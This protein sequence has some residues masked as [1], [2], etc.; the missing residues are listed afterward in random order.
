MY[1]SAAGRRSRAHLA[2]ACSGRMPMAHFTHSNITK[3]PQYFTYCEVFSAPEK[4]RTPDTTVRSR[5]LYPAEL[6]THTELFCFHHSLNRIDFT[7]L[8]RFCQLAIL[9]FPDFFV[10]FWQGS[11]KHFTRSPVLLPW[12]ADSDIPRRPARPPS[13]SSHAQQAPASSKVQRRYMPSP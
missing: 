4:I 7:T 13:P 6:L 5:M 3:T 8:F 11:R 9:L 2:K 1:L 10:I 12:E